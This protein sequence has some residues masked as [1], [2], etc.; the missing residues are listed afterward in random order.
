MLIR[1]RNSFSQLRRQYSPQQIECL[2]HPTLPAT[3]WHFVGGEFAP[4]K[5]RAQLQRKNK[6][7]NFWIFSDAGRRP[8]ALMSASQRAFDGCYY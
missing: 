1:E 3:I 5:L 2:D 4:G 8:A 6:R 7:V